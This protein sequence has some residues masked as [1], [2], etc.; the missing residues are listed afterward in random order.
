MKQKFQFGKT[1]QQWRTDY[2]SAL[3]QIEDLI[4][5]V[6]QFSQDDNAWIS[7]ATTQQLQQQI[8][9]IQQKAAQASDLY[10]DLP[11]Y[12]IPFA[13]KDNID[14]QGFPTTAACK[15]LDRHASEDAYVVRQLKNAG[16]IVVGKTNLDQFATGLVGTRSPYGTVVNSFDPHYVSGGSSSGSAS[17]V[18]RGLVPFALGTDTAG[19]GRVPASFNNIIGLKPSRGR[20]SNRGVFPACKSLDCVSIFTLTVADAEQILHLSE[21][22]DAK[23]SYSR[24]N[25]QTAP[26]N[27][28]K[29]L[30]FAVPK[31]L[32]FCGDTFA[33]QAFQNSLI[34]LKKLGAKITPIDFTPFTQLAEQLYQGA[35]VAERTTALADLLKHQRQHIDPTVLT[36]VEGGYQYTA[37][38]AFQAEYQRQDLARTIQSTLEQFDALIVPTTA[39]IHRIAT[40]IQDPINKNADLGHYTNFTNLADLSALALAAGFRKDGLPFGISLIANAWHDQALLAFGKRWQAAVDLPLGATQHQL[41]LTSLPLPPS[42]PHHIRI[43]VVGAHLSGM[44]L[45]GQLTA[46]QA[47]LVETTET[48]AHYELFALKAST[49]AKPGLSR[50]ATGQHIKVEL[51]DI[52][53]AR[54]GEFVAEVPPPLGI[55][56]IELAD[57]RWVKG[58]ICEAYGLEGAENISH[59]GGWRAYTQHCNTLLEKAE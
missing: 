37:V 16:A 41:S 48:A 50:V 1:L 59:F 51:W 23:D 14:V 34:Q 25:P 35:W 6:A 57:G 9:V 4:E 54:F 21:G 18:A 26:A 28:S 44:P 32:Q 3:F 39:T 55:G 33:A 40:V 13:V 47:V 43:A 58:F 53:T 24:K 15:A 8:Q 46:R 45:N 12:G 36:I 31:Q 49:P 56:N 7:I 22:Y 19:S 38:E 52:P 5:Y 27:F 2:Q 10:Q 29:A 20:L 11:L 30:H 42:S 17:V